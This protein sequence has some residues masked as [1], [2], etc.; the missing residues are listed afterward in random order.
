MFKKIVCSVVLLMASVTCASAAELKI[1]MVNVN[2]VMSKSPQVEAIR[3]KLQAQFA[4]QLSEL[5]KMAED[6]QAKDETLK[7]DALT[8]TEDQRISASRELQSIQTSAQ[9]KQ[10]QLQEDQKRAQQKELRVVEGTVQKAINEIA[11]AEGFDLILRVEVA[12][13]ATKALDISD[14]VIAKISDPAG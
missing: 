3:G 14:K 4:D 11:T 13:F 7:R 5:K 12:L 6:L 8:M 10:K 2:L 9:M 1:G